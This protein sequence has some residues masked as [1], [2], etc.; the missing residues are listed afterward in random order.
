MLVI[1]T[2]TLSEDYELIEALSMVEIT[3]RTEVS[4][5]ALIRGFT[6]RGRDDHQK[7]RHIRS[8]QRYGGAR[9][10]RATR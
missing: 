5:K 3:S 10:Q 4:A 6:E 1:T 2:D 7:A 8:L 9:F